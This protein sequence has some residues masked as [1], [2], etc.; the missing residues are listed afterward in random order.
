MGV[1]LRMIAD[2]RVEFTRTRVECR[3]RPVRPGA[4]IVCRRRFA[5]ARFDRG[6]TQPQGIYR[7]DRELY[8][9]RFLC[10]DK[11]FALVLRYCF[12][13]LEHRGVLVHHNLAG[14]QQAHCIKTF[15]DFLF[16]LFGF[17]GR[18]F[19]FDCLNTLVQNA[20]YPDHFE[21][22]FIWS[23]CLLSLT[24]GNHRHYRG[25]QYRW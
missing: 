17:A 13:S 5:G 9:R 10:H 4:G 2:G 1:I 22:W 23:R 8:L 11:A 3:L 24:T 21:T 12:G 19:T 25:K 18:N 14:I 16:L 15:G 6:V 7:H 20:A